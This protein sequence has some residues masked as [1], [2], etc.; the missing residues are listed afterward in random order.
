MDVISAHAMESVER[1][2]LNAEL[3]ISV[4]VLQYKSTLS[5]AHVAVNVDNT[6]CG[7]ELTGGGV[8][9]G[10]TIDG[11]GGIVVFSISYFPKRL[12]DD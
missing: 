3:L 7:V 12:T 1:N 8:G 6:T 10:V 11:G 5:L 4:V 2:T 9:V